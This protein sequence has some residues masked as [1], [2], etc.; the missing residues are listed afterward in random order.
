ML[1]DIFLIKIYDTIKSELQLLIVK[2]L[3]PTMF[4]I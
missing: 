4:K 1:V 3:I 2:N